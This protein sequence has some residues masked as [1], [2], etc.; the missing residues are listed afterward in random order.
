M[1]T[2]TSLRDE[3]TVAAR[4]GSHALGDV[5]KIIRSDTTDLGFR[6]VPIPVVAASDR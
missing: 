6:P 1:K 5:Q 3:A 4:E 2:A